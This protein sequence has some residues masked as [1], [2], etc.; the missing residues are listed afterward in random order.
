MWIKLRKSKIN[1]LLK[2]Q[3]FARTRSPP[4]Q[5]QQKW[6]PKKRNRTQTTTPCFFATATGLLY[7][8]TEPTD[9]E[10]HIPLSSCIQSG[11]MIQRF[12]SGISTFGSLACA[13]F[14]PHNPIHQQ[15]L[16][17]Q[18]AK[19]RCD[20][21]RCFRYVITALLAVNA[22]VNKVC[23]CTCY[24]LNAKRNG[25]LLPIVVGIWTREELWNEFGKLE[26]WKWNRALEAQVKRLVGR[27]TPRELF[28]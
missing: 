23:A 15:N 7:N 12:A 13:F 24:L 16:S 18:E 14:T 11:G 1:E 10:Q 3:I 8:E 19:N 2:K 6:A 28:L 22:S 17:L 5:R 4:T 27:H 20:N 26:R 25:C 9:S 21:N